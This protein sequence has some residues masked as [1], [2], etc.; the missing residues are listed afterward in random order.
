[1]EFSGSSTFEVLLSLLSLPLLTCFLAI[2]LSFCPSPYVHPNPTR[3]EPANYKK[4]SFKWTVL[5][6]EIFGYF[7]IIST[8]YREI[9][10]LCFRL[11]SWNFHISYLDISHFAFFRDQTKY[12]KL[13]NFRE[14]FFR[15]KCVTIFLFRWKPYIC[16]V[17]RRKWLRTTHTKER[18]TRTNSLSLSDRSKI[19][20]DWYQ[21]Q[22]HYQPILPS[23]YREHFIKY[24]EECPFNSDFLLRS[25]FS[26]WPSLLLRVYRCGS[27]LPTQSTTCSH[28]GRGWWPVYP[29]SRWSYII[30]LLVF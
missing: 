7:R 10:A 25:V 19:S 1:M 13:R 2:F 18:R 24:Y 6:R 30:Y 21:N 5:F 9:F 23:I 11:F 14:N 28:S 26:W 15:E 17:L 27:L 16:C 12:K 22:K 29:T 3:N 4:E 8:F 20:S